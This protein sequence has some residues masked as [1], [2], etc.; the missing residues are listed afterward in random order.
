MR[1]ALP[2]AVPNIVK[3]I[4][5]VFLF[6]LKTLH[7]SRKSLSDRISRLIIDFGAN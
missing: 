6:L 4:Q 2:V 5:G 3:V 1:G 7:R